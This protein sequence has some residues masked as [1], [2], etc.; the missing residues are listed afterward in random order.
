MLVSGSLVLWQVWLW[1]SNEDFET[2][3]HDQLH[4]RS[5]S[6]LHS[7]NQPLHFRFLFVITP[8][9]HHTI[10]TTWRRKIKSL[11][12]RVHQR[13]RQPW[14]W[15]PQGQ[16]QSLWPPTRYSTEFINSLFDWCHNSFVTPRLNVYHNHDNTTVD[17]DDNKSIR[18]ASQEAKDCSPQSSINIPSK[19][20]C[21][22]TIRIRRDANSQDYIARSG[23]VNAIL[24]TITC[25]WCTI[26][27]QYNRQETTKCEWIEEINTC[28][29]FQTKSKAWSQEETKIVR[30]LIVQDR[31]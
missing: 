10:S 15:L 12:L 21:K 17:T 18:Q 27:K 11:T 7:F 14:N 29:G 16:I 4:R 31:N 13:T 19:V 20:C 22:D 5:S 3:G 9:I 2:A 25:Q 1:S 24:D 28:S 30:P 6:C 8:V 26:T 23:F